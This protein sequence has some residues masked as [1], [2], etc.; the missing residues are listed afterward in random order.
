MVRHVWA[1]QTA[2]KEAL[3]LI[4]RAQAICEGCRLS[5]RVRSNGTHQS[6]GTFCTAPS[7]RQQLREMSPTHRNRRYAR[8]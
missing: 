1:L 8:S 7:E 4:A 3:A 2:N 5:W 6:T